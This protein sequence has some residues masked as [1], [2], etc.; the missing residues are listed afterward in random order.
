MLDE[1]RHFFGKDE[2]KRILE[3]M[4]RLGLNVFH[5]HLTDDQGW[6]IDL[7]GMPELAQ[8]GAIRPSSPLRGEDNS[9]DGTP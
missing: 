5:W 1:A 8:F 2:V 4:A 7:Q 6:R 3:R 9:S